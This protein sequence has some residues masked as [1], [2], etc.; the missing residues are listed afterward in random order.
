VQQGWKKKRKW[1]K[2]GAREARLWLGRRGD[3]GWFRAAQGVPTL[4]GK[5]QYKINTGGREH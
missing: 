4:I 1:R 2:K 5:K 3:W